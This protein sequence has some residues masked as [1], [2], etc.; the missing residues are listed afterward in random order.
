MPL[1]DK[2]CMGSSSQLFG[3]LDFSQAVDKSCDA[4]SI[5]ASYSIATTVLV[6]LQYVIL[7]RLGWSINPS[8]NARVAWIR[9]Y[10]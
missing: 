7:H 9:S 4:W 3:G 8:E 1:L 2:L 10:L 5:S 6:A